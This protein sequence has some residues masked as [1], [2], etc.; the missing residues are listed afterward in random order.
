[1]S[2]LV[3]NIP[4]IEV[5]IDKKYLYD[6]QKNE[7]GDF[8]GDGEW[9]RGHWVT[10]KSISNRALLFET[11]ID[12]YGAIY[13]KLP[14]SAFRWHLG[15]LDVEY[16]LDWLQIWDCL[17]YDIS[18]IEKRALRFCRTQTLLKDKSLVEGEYLFTIDTTH[19]NPAEI[20]T[21]WSE[22]PN[23]HK[24]YNICKIENGQFVAQPNNRTR[25]I[26]P[27]RTK[28]NLPTPYFR[29]STKVWSVEA[30][31]KWV[32]DE[33]WNYEKIIKKDL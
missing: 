3:A 25:F 12:E 6:F 13:D 14:I 26:Q 29:Y 8:L 30:T 33:T 5:W 16:P 17:S 11:Y 19:S 22:T 23:E 18:I 9:E 31:D 20:D 32:D 1:V 10:V 21:G 7:N 15:R 27:S 4:P 24:S 28:N 2:Y